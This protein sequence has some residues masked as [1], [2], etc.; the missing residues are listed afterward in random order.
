MASGASGAELANIVNEAALRAMRNRRK[1]AS[2]TD[3]EESLEVVIT[4]S[5][6]GRI[7]LLVALANVILFF[8]ND[9]IAMIK[10]A[11]RRYEF[12]KGSGNFRR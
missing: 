11:K 1:S 9:F 12:R 10:N 5:W 8:S 2:Q 4:G 6:A 7:A 3:F